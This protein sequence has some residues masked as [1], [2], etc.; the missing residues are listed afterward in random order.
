M[1]G[2][3]LYNDNSWLDILNITGFIN[4]FT[5]EMGVHD[6]EIVETKLEGI[7]AGMKMDFPH[8]DGENKA[9]PFKK[10][11]NFLCYFN[12]ER[13]LTKPFPEAIIG[14]EL[15]KISNHQNALVSFF[16][17][18]MALHGATIF[19]DGAELKIE[20]PIKISKHSLKDIIDPLAIVTPRDHFKLV[21]VLLE[22]LVYK[23][24]P[25]LQYPI[26]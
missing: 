9:S 2:K 15:Y 10:A 13:P 11:A 3:I 17:V 24:N 18:R 20:Q 16:F 5:R 6:V 7:V 21:H 22:Q 4:E 1:S 12:A 23:T 26:A 14:E 19:R 25:D 8:C